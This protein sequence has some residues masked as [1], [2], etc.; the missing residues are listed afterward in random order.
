MTP[1]RGRKALAAR[2]EELRHRID[3]AN[4]AYYVADSPTIA[5]AEYD[6]LFRELREIEAAHPEL[7]TADSPTR[8]VGAEPASALSKHP[9]RRPMLSLAN[10][11]DAA[12][13]AQWEE[14]NARNSP[15]VREAG[16]VV[17]VKIDG[18][19]VNLTYEDGRFV[20]GATRGNGIIGEDVTANLRTVDDVPLVLRGKGWPRLMEVRGEVYMPYES[21]KRLNASRERDGE[22]LFANP[23]NAAAGGLRQLD[24]SITRRRRLRLFTFSIEALDGRL[25]APTHMAT[26]DLLASWG[27]PVEPHR[28]RLPDLAAVQEAVPGFEALLPTL[29]FQA[30][31]MVVKVDQLRLHAELGVVGGREPRWAIARKFAPEVA[32]TRLR[33]IRIN[34]GRTGALNPYAELEPVEVS[35]VIVSAATLHNEELIAQK[36]IRAGDWVEIIRAGEVI[37]QIVAPLPA[38]RTGGEAPFVMPDAC[39]ACG[40]P[41]ERPEGEAMR[42]CPNVSC[43]ARVLEGIV[44][45]AGREAM[46]IRG[47][48]YER[49]RQLL[50][51]G[52]IRDVA[53]LYE[54]R[55]EALVELDRFAAQSAEQLV[56]AIDASRAQPLS[57]LL[58]G[59][60]IRHVGKTVA[61]IL[62]RRFGTMDRLMDA[63]HG[64]IAE[65]NGIGPTIA[66]AVAGFFAEARNRELIGRLRDA[67]LTFTEPLAS[68]ASGPLAGRTF[69]LTGTLPTLSRAE[70]TAL[71]ER[72][73]GHVSGSVSRKT[74]AVVAGDDAG[75]KLEKARSLGVEVIDETELLRRA[76]LPGDANSSMA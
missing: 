8:R 34:V 48:G 59:L 16:Y 41:V 58:F 12:E 24:P 63:P 75:S 33:A 7:Q 18:A 71:I 47:L 27:F 40:T 17:E 29:P 25:D 13:L 55:S 61:Q 3:E 5:D 52:L 11:F 60:G 53:D 69:V 72:A 42:Y 10:A 32:V 65:V 51:A 9:H 26:L 35:G 36:D 28:K 19:A 37:P 39:P 1:A 64:A 62:A 23:R 38:R 2:A 15:E 73:G 22:Q 68:D 76:A 45:F 74:G 66:E 67:K 46:D 56:R 50:S 14:R 43:P 21:F 6:A 49:V 4:D 44:H 54:L 30:D 57:L 31:G 70:A 20:V